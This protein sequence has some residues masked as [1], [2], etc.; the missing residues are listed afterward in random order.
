MA[1]DILL[2]GNIG[3]NDLINF[4][5]KVLK[6]AMKKV[7][8]DVL[9]VHLNPAQELVQKEGE[10]KF[11][12]VLKLI[13]E[14]SKELPIYVKEC[15]QGISEEVAK[16]LSTA[17][18]KAIDVGGSGGTSWPGIE[19]LRRGQ[20]DGPFWDW[21]IPTA[22]SIIEARKGSKL[23]IIAT[24]GIRSGQDIVKAIILGASVGS[25]ALPLLKTA[26]IDSSEKYLEDLI[27]EIGDT[28]FL[29]GAR[30]VADLGK[31]RVIIKGDL[32]D[33]TT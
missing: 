27:K 18:I 32:K 31:C 26:N 3:A 14:Y 25:A 5:P 20:E 17:N 7:G 6:D 8:V 15:G 16:K 29:I 19:Y 10:A 2:V 24:G 28:M 11:K 30:T 13:Q 12:G 9:A 4:S 33:L 22:L 21:G 23:P 1:P